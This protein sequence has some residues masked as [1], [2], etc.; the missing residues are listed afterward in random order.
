M[1]GNHQLRKNNKTFI[2]NTKRNHSFYSGGGNLLYLNM[3][4]TR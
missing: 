1:I 3:L 2:K 4:L